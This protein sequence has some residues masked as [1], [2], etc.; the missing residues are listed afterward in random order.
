[1]LYDRAKIYIKAGNGGNGSA[2]FRREKFVPKGGP[3][4]GDGGRGGSVFLEVDPHLNTLLPFRYKTHF[5]AQP[6]GN[7]HFRKQHGSAGDDLYIKVPPG[8]MF[9]SE[10]DPDHPET[11]VITGDLVEP[12]QK[13]MVARGGRGGLGNVHFATSTNQAPRLAYDGEP[14]QELWLRLELKL[15]ADVGLVGFP[16]AGKSTLLSVVSAA[17]PKIAN[18]PFTTLEPNLGVVGVGDDY[19]FVLADIPGLIEGASQGVG[20]GHEFLRHVERTRLLIHLIDGS[21]Q[22]ERGPIKDYEQINKELAEYDTELS[23][24]PQI[25]VINKIDLPEAQEN[26]PKL[27]EYFR[28][29]G[30]EPQVISAATHQGTTALMQ[31][32]AQRLQEM[33]L[34]TAT[35]SLESPENLP[36]LRPRGADEDNR[37]EVSKEGEHEFRVRGRRIERVVAMTNMGN[38]AALA[39]LQITLEKMGISPA[40]KRAGVHGGDSVYFGNQELVWQSED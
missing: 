5:K 13:I 32:V 15:I 23:Q 3:D 40:L 2:S 39:Q 16:N 30:I 9:Y 11:P 31:L 21:D 14:G 10:P 20:L 26:L 8:T 18:Y 27:K 35:T 4:G 36:I 1:M 38:E 33:P 22:A 34:P 24:K 28:E 7:G 12:G 25:V 17:T 29:R 19:S 37:F 6:G